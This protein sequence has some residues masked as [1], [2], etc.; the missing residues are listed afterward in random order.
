MSGTFVVDA[1]IALTIDDLIDD[2]P[3]VPREA[4]EA[5]EFYA[6]AHPLRE[7]PSARPWHTLG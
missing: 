4:F 7:R 2:Y 5:A 3:E 6:W 1:S